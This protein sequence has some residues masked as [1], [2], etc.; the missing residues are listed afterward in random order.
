[1]R[2]FEPYYNVIYRIPTN[3]CALQVRVPKRLYDDWERKIKQ[4]GGT[5]IT[6]DGKKIPKSTPGVH[7]TSFPSGAEW[8]NRIVAA[9]RPF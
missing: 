9:P 8:P 5:L 4:D 1:M 3:E 6:V 7:E 2:K